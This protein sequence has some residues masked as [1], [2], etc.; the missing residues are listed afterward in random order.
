[1]GIGHNRGDHYMRYWR[2]GW[3]DG[4]MWKNNEDHKK[5]R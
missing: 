1:M 2:I 3:V 5:V 4:E